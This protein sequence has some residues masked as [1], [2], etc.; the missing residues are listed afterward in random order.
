[1]NH[2]YYKHK[3]KKLTA[4]KK[5]DYRFEIPELASA[6][7]PWELIW[8]SSDWEVK[9]DYMGNCYSELVGLTESGFG[10]DSGEAIE[11]IKRNLGITKDSILH[12]TRN[13]SE[14]EANPD[15]VINV[16]YVIDMLKDRGLYIE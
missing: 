16:R 7:V 2:T 11:V 3:T 1:M 9:K 12:L 5:D 8:W 14:D 15:Y 4:V 10:Y 6:I 13:L